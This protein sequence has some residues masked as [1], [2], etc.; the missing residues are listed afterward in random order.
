MET[1]AIHR[2]IE[3]SDVAAAI[4]EVAAQLDSG[5]RELVLD[6]SSVGRIDTGALCALDDLARG[7]DDKS[8][9]VKLHGVNLDVYKALKLVNLTS[10]FSFVN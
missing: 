1:I 5:D 3:Q 4:R 8:I 9:K 7:A 10:R 2:K 6:F